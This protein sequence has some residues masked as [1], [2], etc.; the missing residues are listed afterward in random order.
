MRATLLV[1]AVA[2]YGA[3]AAAAPLSNVV[4]T[5]G[6]YRVAAAGDA[7]E[8]DW[9]AVRFEFPITCSSGEGNITVSLTL[10]SSSDGDASGSH[11]FA[12]TLFDAQRS[13]VSTGVLFT[14]TITGSP[15]VFS[16]SLAGAGAGDFVVSVQKRT[17]A[18]FGVVSLYTATVTGS[19]ASQ[20][21]AQSRV[22]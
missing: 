14:T 4:F 13:A 17:E 19:G 10:S 11:E 15:A 9:P 3:V 12:V 1:A 7:F 22:P 21:C 16:V 8:F 2:V 5:Q 6:R 20:V 18:L